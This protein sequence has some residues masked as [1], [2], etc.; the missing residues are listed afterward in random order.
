MSERKTTRKCLWNGYSTNNFAVHWDFSP[1]RFQDSGFVLTI[2]A[3]DSAGE[4]LLPI[5]K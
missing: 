2:Y 5:T 3:Y 4:I 1:E